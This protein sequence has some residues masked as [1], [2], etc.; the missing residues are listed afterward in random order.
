MNVCLHFYNGKSYD[1]EQLRLS[2]DLR[3]FY[4]CSRRWSIAISYSQLAPSQRES[5]TA[6][7]AAHNFLNNQVNIIFFFFKLCVWLRSMMWIILILSIVI[8]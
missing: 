5:N 8:Y 1:R 3:Q 4:D 7:E 6:A 2:D